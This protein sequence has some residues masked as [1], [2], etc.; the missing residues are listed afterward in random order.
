M[1]LEVRIIT[2]ERVFLTCETEQ[3]ILPAVNGGIGILSDHAPL[4][5][6][7]EPGVV[8]YESNGTWT[9][10]ILYGGFAEVENNKITVLVNGAEEVSSS[11]NLQSIEKAFIDATEKLETLKESK[12]NPREVD[13]AAL[14]VRIAKARLD[15]L[16]SLKS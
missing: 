12:A 4:V 5:T 11:E 7:L 8:R 9:P 16:T 6:V 1:S 14:E 3:V 2:P 10:A 15:A 13:S